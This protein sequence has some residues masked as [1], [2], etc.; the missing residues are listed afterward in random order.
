MSDHSLNQ[1]QN[2]QKERE[3]GGRKKGGGEVVDKGDRGREKQ[4][5]Y[6]FPL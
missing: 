3:V 2:L 5:E 6:S 4:R 1:V